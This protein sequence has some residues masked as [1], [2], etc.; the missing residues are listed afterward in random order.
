VYDCR[1]V[2]V[3]PERP[4]SRRS[5][6]TT[7]ACI[8]RLSLLATP[9]PESLRMSADLRVA[10]CQVNRVWCPQDARIQAAQQYVQAAGIWVT[11]G[12]NVER[13][14]QNAT[15]VSERSMRL[16]TCGWVLDGEELRDKVV[17]SPTRLPL[18]VVCSPGLLRPFSLLL[19]ATC[20]S[21]CPLP[22]FSSWFEASGLP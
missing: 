5:G 18:C 9:E 3:V 14:S 16:L 15:T 7:S 6:V 12:S 20:S 17:E 10:S 21:G 4:E 2:T 13:C 19:K 8:C 22:P 1:Y 11:D